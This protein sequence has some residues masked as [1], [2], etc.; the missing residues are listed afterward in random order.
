VN[1]PIFSDGEFR[2]RCDLMC[3]ITERVNVADGVSVISDSNT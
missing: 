3:S 2:S 1:L